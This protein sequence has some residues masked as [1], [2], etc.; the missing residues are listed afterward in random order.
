ML[1]AEQ[2][3][4]ARAALR[5]GIR[6]TAKKAKLSTKTVHQVEKGAN[7]L[8]STLTEL[9]TVYEKAGIVFGADGSVRLGERRQRK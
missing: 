9:Q 1:T 4:M 3:R 2:A 7:A 6:D 8:A 5:W